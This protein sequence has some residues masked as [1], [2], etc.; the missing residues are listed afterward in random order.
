MTNVYA[1]P[2]VGALGHEW[3][4]VDPVDVSRSLITGADYR[5]AAQRSRRMATLVVS[6]IDNTEAGAGYM[7]SLKRLLAGRHAVRLYSKPVNWG[8]RG[9]NALRNKAPLTWENSEGSVTWEDSEGSVTWEYR[10]LTVT[11]TGTD[12]LGFATVTISGGPANYLIARPGEFLTIYSDPAQTAEIVTAAQTDGTG[13]ATIRVFGSLASAI[14]AAV[15][16]GTS[17]TGVFLP[18]GP[19]P[20]AVRPSAG[21]W[22]YTWNFRELFEDEVDGSF[23]EIDPW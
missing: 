10:P 9:D 22:S 2:P 7:E 4:R 20:R 16:I 17:D 23:V 1:W 13:A 3:T 14:G 15:S 18:V 11:A 8:G 6:G 12:S 21:D 5:S 19:Y